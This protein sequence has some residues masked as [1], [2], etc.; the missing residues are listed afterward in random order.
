M[1]YTDI[2]VR[3]SSTYPTGFFAISM[4]IVGHD[5]CDV[6]VSKITGLEYPRIKAANVG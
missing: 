2:S 6:S 5:K 4:Q 1:L 3:I